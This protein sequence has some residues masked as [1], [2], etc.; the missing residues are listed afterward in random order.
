MAK[1]R[2]QLTEQLDLAERLGPRAQKRTDDITIN[3]TVIREFFRVMLDAYTKRTGRFQLIHHTTDGPQH[4]YVPGQDNGGFA[5]PDMFDER[6]RPPKMVVG[7]RAFLAYYYLVV[8]TDHLQ[9]SDKLYLNHTRLYADHP[10]VYSEKVIDLTKER[11]AQLFKDYSIGIHNENARFFLNNAVTLYKDFDGDPVE[12][13]RACGSTVDGVLAWR[14]NYEKEHG[15]NPLLGFE[16]KITSLYLLYLAEF[17]ALPFPRD[18]F[19]VDV[20]IIF[21]LYQVGG[22]ILH[23]RMDNSVIARILRETICDICEE[24]QFDKISLANVLWLN[25][26][27]GCNRCSSNAA[28]ELLCP[29]WNMCVGRYATDNYHHNGSIDP[30]DPLFPKGGVRP[31]YGI[32]RIIRRRPEVKGRGP[33][34]IEPRATLFDAEFQEQEGRKVIPI[35][36]ARKGS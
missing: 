22:F 25:G 26:S 31:A 12:I 36:S 17:G 19:A 3:K 33:I 23:K 15:R 29:A 9:D 4:K 8:P 18:A 14:N 1:S 30:A 32:Q 20:H 34:L 27:K 5:Q 21:Q 35:A 16:H 2:Q 24:E 11:L 7:S 28:A 10:W 13:F 6:T